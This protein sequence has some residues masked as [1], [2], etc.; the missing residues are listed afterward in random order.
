MRFLILN[1]ILVEPFTRAFLLSHVRQSFCANHCQPLAMPSSVA[2]YQSE[3]LIMTKRKES[4]NMYSIQS[5]KEVASSFNELDATILADAD[6]IFDSI[7]IDKNNEISGEELRSHLV[8]FGCSPESIRFLFTVLDTNDDGIISRDEMRF[9]FEN[10]ELEDLRL[11]F[12]LGTKSTK[13]A[14]DDAVESIRSSHTLADLIFDTIDVDGSGEIDTDEL[15]T[16]FRENFDSSWEIANSSAISVD[17][18]LDLLDLDDSGTI[19]REEMRVGFEQF[20]GLR[21]IKQ[22]DGNNLKI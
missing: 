10:Y 22:V 13:G 6:S 8:A 21:V 1:L 14:Y 2:P 9:A 18:I 4:T 19:S 3:A 17:T 20:E 16:H 7:D 11:A 12:G 15:I 5:G